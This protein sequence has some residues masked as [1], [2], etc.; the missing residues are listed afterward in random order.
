MFEIEIGDSQ[1]NR[2][3]LAQVIKH[4]VKNELVS[5]ERLDVLHDQIVAI[6]NKLI[7]VKVRDSS[8]EYEVENWIT[9]AFCLI[10]LGLEYASKG[11]LV[12]AAKLL[13]QND[14]IKFFQIGNT[15]AKR[16]TEYARE[17]K[18]KGILFSSVNNKIEVVREELKIY[19]VYEEEFLEAL[20]SLQ[21]NTEHADVVIDSREKLRPII[22]I[23]DLTLARTMLNNLEL[24]S[25]Y[26]R[27]V[28]KNKLF[29]ADFTALDFIDSSKAATQALMINL[30]LYRQLEFHVTQKDIDEF[31]DTFYE[32]ESDTIKSDTVHLLT[33]WI[34]NFLEEAGQT[35]QVKSYTV[36]YW[37]Y[38]LNKLKEN[39]RS[40]D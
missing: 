18:E 28:T 40:K 7:T 6:S 30:A 9:N 14:L 21:L 1:N 22:S 36:K 5:T 17:V 3:F 2:I 33:D 26:Y 35:E 32:E 25:K 31:W 37:H 39:L 11:D 16:L 27:T 38:C 24:R 20:L 15:L 4:G 13:S 29:D 19:N 34:E 23:D 12:K 8:S 10:S